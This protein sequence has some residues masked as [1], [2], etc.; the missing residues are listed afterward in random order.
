MA[1]HSRVWG[2]QVWRLAP[3]IP[4]CPLYWTESCKKRLTALVNLYIILTE[5]LFEYAA[6]EA[7]IMVHSE[8]DVINK[9]RNSSDP[10][11]SIQI[12]TEIILDY[13]MQR[14]S[15]QLQSAALPPEPCAAT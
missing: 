4:K 15:S 12:A 8:M 9:I 11:R 13:L 5:H 10:E 7:G 14:E 2:V 3:H 6:W 1:Y